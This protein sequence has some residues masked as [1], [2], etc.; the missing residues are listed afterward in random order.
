VQALADQIA[1]DLKLLADLISLPDLE[2]AA[3]LTQSEKTQPRVLTIARPSTATSASSSR[4]SGANSHRGYFMVD[5]I[6]VQVFDGETQMYPQTPSRSPSLRAVK[7]TS[8]A[9]T[10]ARLNISPT[11]RRARYHDFSPD[12]GDQL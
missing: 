2:P 6:Q 4:L 7:R 3:A 5:V 12:S 11:T 8:A 10:T 1:N 9:S